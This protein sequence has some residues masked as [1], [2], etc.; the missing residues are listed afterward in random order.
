LKNSIK[1]VIKTTLSISA[2]VLTSIMLCGLSSTQAKAENFTL[3]GGMSL[4]TNNAF[5]P[6]DGSPRLSLYA[7]N[8]SDPDQIFERI[9]GNKGGT[10]LKNKTTGK[11][12]NAHY[13]TN[14]GK[15]N[16]CTCDSNDIDQNF[17]LLDQG[18][19]IFVLRRTGT[20]TCINSPQHYNN[21]QVFMWDCNT[22]DPDQRFTRN[23]LVLFSPATPQSAGSGGT[24]LSSTYRVVEHEIFIIAKQ[25][26]GGDIARV[27]NNSLDIGHATTAI[28]PV[29]RIY[30][31]GT[32]TSSKY[33]LDV[34]QITT[35]S[36]WPDTS[37]YPTGMCSRKNCATDKAV[38]VD[39][40]GKGGL[41]NVASDGAIFALRRQKITESSIAKIDAIAYSATQCSSYA[42]CTCVDESTR[43][44]VYLTGEDFRPDF[45]FNL[46]K[47]S[48]NYVYSK[49]INANNA[50][51]S[52]GYSNNGMY[53]NVP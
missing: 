17:D 18:N 24:L 6:V 1:R 42:L 2:T 53:L 40:I 50:V 22:S 48:P 36:Y 4:N 14:N 52:Q 45:T 28:V 29:E 15:V 41:N 12:I 7:Q 39:V 19:N 37:S 31:N 38:T 8:N 5:A 21:G 27:F 9:T 16:V 11:C 34:N 25:V 49:L 35:Y 26:G 23:G 20:N 33:I 43:L 30:T 3:S 10:L 47:A 44:W 13:P 46:L 32:L 51:N